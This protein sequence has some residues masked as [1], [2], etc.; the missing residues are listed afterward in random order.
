MAE[1]QG[2]LMY[3]MLTNDEMS[4]FFVGIPWDMTNNMIQFGLF[5]FQPS[6]NWKSNEIHCLS[7][8]LP[9]QEVP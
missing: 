5:G 8:M 4:T 6:N 7:I 3:L 1:K 2:M 9:I